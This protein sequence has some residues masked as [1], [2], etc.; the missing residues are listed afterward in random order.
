MT[1]SASTAPAAGPPI[2][3]VEQHRRLRARLRWWLPVGAALLLLLG[4]QLATY[5]DRAALRGYAYRQVGVQ[6]DSTWWLLAYR[7]GRAEVLFSRDTARGWQRRELGVDSSQAR[8]L[9]L[10]WGGK[11]LLV[12]AGGAVRVYDS[13]FRPLGPVRY[14]ANRRL[15][16]R[17]LA[18][19]NTGRLAVVIGDAGQLHKTTDGGHAWGTGT[20]FHRVA[21]GNKNGGTGAERA[22][23]GSAGD[24]TLVS[25]YAYEHFGVHAFEAGSFPVADAGRRWSSAAAASP[26][27]HFDTDDDGVVRALR[28]DGSAEIGPVHYPPDQVSDKFP[29]GET[30]IGAA[31]SPARP[32]FCLL[33]SAGRVFAGRLRGPFATLRPTAEPDAA[34]ANS[35][36]APPAKAPQKATASGNKAPATPAKAAKAVKASGVK[37]K[38][39]KSKSLAPPKAL[40]KN[41]PA[42][43]K[44]DATKPGSEQTRPKTGTDPAPNQF[45]NQTAAP[46]NPANQTAPDPKPVTDP[47]SQPPIR[48]NDLRSP[49][50]LLPKQERKYKD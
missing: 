32:G 13:L 45:P 22:D 38:A 1:E 18:A 4:Y 49:A 10:N 48:T 20:F 3:L 43:G 46:T 11:A 15:R 9:V 39:P 5:P 31:F 19:D 42:A 40:Q 27:I 26:I 21:F 50:P 12:G 17:G 24:L 36:A 33:I 16:P 7:N 37:A 2:D 34:G 47:K 29:A 28:Q 25:R 14:L 44:A 23:F 30:L 8:A 6:P 35:A 41:R